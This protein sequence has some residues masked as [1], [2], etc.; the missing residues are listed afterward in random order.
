MSIASRDL[1]RTRFHGPE[2]FARFA[3]HGV[4]TR[5]GASEHEPTEVLDPATGAVIGSVPSLE[6]RHMRSAIAEAQAAF[7]AWRRLLPRQRGDLL[8]EW[9]RLILEASDDLA[10]LMTAEQGKPLADA[11]G[12]IEYGAEFIRWFAEEASRAYGEVIPSHLPGRRLFVQREPI[13][14]VGLV[15]PWNFPSAMLTRK[16]AAALAAGC[17]AVA[18]PSPETPFSALAL[19]DLAEQ[20][21]LP[22][23][24]FSVLTGA[25]EELVG[26]L[27]HSPV[28]RALSFTGSTRVGRLIAAQCAPTLKRVSLELGG[29][30]PFIVFEDADVEAAAQAAVDAKF[31][32]SG[33]DCLAA[34]RIFVQQPIY[35]RFVEAFVR[36]A[37][38]LRVGPGG[39]AA[40]DMGPL[41]NRAT[42]AKSAE[43][44]A[45]ALAKGARLVL[46]GAPSGETLMF[47]PTALA[48][49][50]A[51]M[52][53]MREETFG[54]VAALTPFAD[55]AEVIAAAND[56]DYGL[57]AYVFT[58][59][60]SRAYRLCDALEYGMV[61]VNTAK[62]TGAPIPFG[63][64][65]QSG[66]GR[67]GSRHGLDEYTELKYVC[68]AV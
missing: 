64:V 52:K 49:A 45:D 5:W 7:P 14:V 59:D 27:C 23:G 31:Q 53:I 37:S 34:N 20:A 16:A 2:A 33:Q 55:E 56:T 29:H 12:E 25:P 46:G 54:P 42:F 26:E 6:A 19:A 41:I 50:T 67:E 1:H 60:L 48:D 24:V 63:G 4:L 32:T 21:G 66:L 58:R 18:V 9:R 11:R 43:H 15:T 38:S 57:A 13:G 30:A 3:G 68:M 17:T 44:V 8:M 51:E 35:P 10:A 47:P 39:E 36:K 40:S 22:P 65:K 28:V 61:A 62:L